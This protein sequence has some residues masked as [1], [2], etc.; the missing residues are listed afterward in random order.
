[1][2]SSSG[3]L[4]G[5]NPI[6][7]GA[8]WTVTDYSG[9]AYVPSQPPYP[10]SATCTLSM[11]VHVIAKESVVTPYGTYEAYKVYYQ[12]HA[13]NAE[14][15]E[16][17]SEYIW[18]VPY[19]GQVKWES[20]SEVQLL[21][22]MSIYTPPVETTAKN[23]FNS[24]GIADILRK[25]PTTGEVMILFM[26][27][28][29]TIAGTKSVYTNTSWPVMGTGDF[30]EDGIC[31]IVRRRASDGAVAILY[32]NANGTYASMETVYINA[33]W[34]VVGTGDFNGDGTYDIVRRR[35]SDGA[36]SILYMNNDG[37]LAGNKTVYI[38]SNWEIVGP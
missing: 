6:V 36:V 14:F 15:N 24:D 38:N 19:V 4:Y 28:D 21:S 20:E 7:V 1:M 29:G 22:D 31:D 34:T 37:S 18:F 11:Y 12:L 3:L 26:N 13:W 5:Q 8:S 27:S 10:Y 30:N 2:T 25:N 16:T 9:N 32:M 17:V 33:N 23:D 35:T